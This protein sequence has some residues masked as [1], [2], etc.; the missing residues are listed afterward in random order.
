MVG[1]SFKISKSGTRY[2]PKLSIA[3]TQKNGVAAEPNKAENGVASPAPQSNFAS[4]PELAT[5][6]LKRSVPEGRDAVNIPYF[7]KARGEVWS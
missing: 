7:K 2:I 4:Q 1:I 3:R 6:N 5:S